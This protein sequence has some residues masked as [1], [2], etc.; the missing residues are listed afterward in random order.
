MNGIQ[1]SGRIIPNHRIISAIREHI[2]S[3]K[4]LPCTNK[5]IRI[6]ESAQAGVIVAALEVVHIC[7]KI[8]HIAAVAEGVDLC[9]QVSLLRVVGG[10][11]AFAVALIMEVDEPVALAVSNACHVT[12][13]TEDIV[14]DFFVVCQGQQLTGSIVGKVHDLFGRPNAMLAGMFLL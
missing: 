7:A 3:G 13:Q 2:V 8:Q 6:D 10:I 11:V 1:A 4:A 9:Q 5:S 14:V 12:L